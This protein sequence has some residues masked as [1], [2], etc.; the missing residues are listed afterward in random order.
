M[1]NSC[2]PKQTKADQ[3][4]PKLTKVYFGIPKQTEAD[5]ID[6]W[7]SLAEIEGKMVLCVLFNCLQTNSC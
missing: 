4:R 5:H 2:V 6:D 3:S 1:T 7:D